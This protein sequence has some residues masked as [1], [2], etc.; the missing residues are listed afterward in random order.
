MLSASNGAV[1]QLAAGAFAGV[2][3]QVLWQLHHSEVSLW[4]H[5]KPCVVKISGEHALCKK[6]GAFGSD[7][8]VG[9]HGLAVELCGCCHGA[10]Y[11]DVTKMSAGCRTGTTL[12]SSAVICGCQRG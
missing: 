9:L 12:C 11:A 7:S 6:V 4:L 1:R 5:C 3:T 10:D 2:H 8:V